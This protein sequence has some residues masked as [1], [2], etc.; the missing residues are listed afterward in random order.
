MPYPAEI[1]PSQTERQYDVA[2]HT[3]RWPAARRYL[4][5]CT[6]GFARFNTPRQLS[7]HA[8][9][10]PFERSSGSSVRGRTQVSHQADK[11]L[12]TLLHMS[13]LVSVREP[14]ELRQYFE[15]KRAEGRS[16]SWWS[17]QCNKL[18]HRVCAVIR[19]NRPYERRP[20]TTT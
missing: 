14:G 8:G 17:M 12:K 16:R 7:C 19:N 5:A 18:V 1:G 2:H 13:A 15:R 11:S 6:D 4:V 3:R 9:V 20:I 10:A